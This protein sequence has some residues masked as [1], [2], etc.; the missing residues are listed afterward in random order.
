MEENVSD[1][2]RLVSAIEQ[3][4]PEIAG[5]ICEEHIMRFFLRCLNIKK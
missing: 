3:Q 5:N 1:L 4:Q 2:E